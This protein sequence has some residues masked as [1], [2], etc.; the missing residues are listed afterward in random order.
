MSEQSA[1]KMEI[2]EVIEVAAERF[3]Q[4]APR[5][6]T[7]ASEKGF[8][9]QALKANDYLMKVAQADPHSLQAAIC[10]VAA[11]GLSLSPAEH[12]AYLVPRKGKVCLDV[13]YQGFCRLGTNSG[14]IQWIQADLIYSED[15]FMVA[16]LGERPVHQ[17][18]PFG[19]RGEFRGVYAVAKTKDGDYLT[20]IMT[21]AEI[22]DVRGRSEA[23]KTFLEKGKSCP[24]VT[25]FNEMG[26]KTVV[27]RAFK[28]WPRTDQHALERMALAVE[29]SNQA[30]QFEPL[31]TSPQ[32]AIASDD[33]KKYFDQLIST[34]DALGMAVFKATIEEGTFVHLYN[35]F[36]KG[37]IGTYKA[38]V[39][40][41]VQK[42]TIDIDEYRRAIT[43]AA[44]IGDNV[45]ATQLIEELS[46]EALDVVLLGVAE[47]ACF[48]I[49]GL[50]H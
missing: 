24:W 48:F 43:E 26:K 30:E 13:S 10:N 4:I 18:D 21:K 12:L 25:D 2:A 44:A 14:S 7:Y 38:L 36:E 47:E 46:T 27:R 41:L 19:D 16:G 33:Q 50:D 17:F 28:M 20:T 31:K 9:I 15:K 6:L 37:N 8:A 45:A 23:Y 3:A 11:I 5:G 35:S 29:L 40:D 39:N 42:G 34:S 22:E 1:R 32:L 49:R